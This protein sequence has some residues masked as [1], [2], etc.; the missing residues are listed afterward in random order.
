[1]TSPAYLSILTRPLLLLTLASLYGCDALDPERGCGTARWTHL[2]P[3]GVRVLSIAETSHGIWAGT[4]D[5]GVLAHRGGREWAS[6]GLTGSP[7]YALQEVDGRILAGR[8]APQPLFATGDGGHTWEPSW[9]DLTGSVVRLARDPDSPRRVVRTAAAPPEA[10][11]LDGGRTWQR[12][13]VPEDFGSAQ[14]LIVLPDD[15]IIGAGFSGSS[16]ATLLLVQGGQ[17]VW[18]DS[19]PW[20]T[21]GGSFGGLAY[22]P[23]RPDVVYAA[24][25]AGIYISRNGGRD[26]EAGPLDPWGYEQ[27][28]GMEFDDGNLYIATRA[29]DGAGSSHPDQDR[30]GFHRYRPGGRVCALNV[31]ARAGGAE[32]LLRVGPGEFLVGTYGTGVWRV[33]VR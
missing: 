28:T 31:P 24:H 22:D 26:W 8:N 21:F 15:R 25:S 1:L 29:R 16:R 12:L 2:G 14:A 30:L 3:D 27:P 11:T 20:T 5:R 4:H 33:R 13:P 10:E 9:D 19:V 18:T 23:V 6:L 32:A 7:V 17:V